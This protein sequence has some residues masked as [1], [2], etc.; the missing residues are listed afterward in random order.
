[1]RKDDRICSSSRPETNC[2]ARRAAKARLS[3]M[4]REFVYRGRETR[5]EIAP[6]QTRTASASAR[7]KPRRSSMHSSSPY[8]REASCGLDRATSGDRSCQNN[9]NRRTN[10]ATR[11]KRSATRNSTMARGSSKLSR[12]VARTSSTFGP[13]SCS[14]LKPGPRDFRST[15]RVLRCRI[16]RQQQSGGRNR[17]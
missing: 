4:L 11:S 16:L 9:R 10:A 15:L 3:V 12:A 5:L 1:M 14:R 17:S 7:A 2:V 13:C 6:R 8:S